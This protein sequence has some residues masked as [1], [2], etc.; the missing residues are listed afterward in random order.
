M[1][2]K[3]NKLSK[4]DLR[5]A[6]ASESS[7]FTPWLSKEE[8]INELG[9]TIGLDLTF[10]N[11][12]HN[13]GPYRADIICKDQVSDDIVLIENQLERTNHK[14]LGQ[15]LTY[16]SGTKAKTIV[17]IAS[18][19]TDEHR[20][21]LDWLNNHTSESF[22]FFGIE[23]ELL[24]I[25]ESDI[26]PNFKLVSKPN[27]W[28][29]DG[30]SYKPY[31]SQSSNSDRQIACKDYWQHTASMIKENKS[32]LKAQKPRAQHWYN[33]AVG[34]QGFKIAGTVKTKANTIG[35]EIYI[36]DNKQAFKNLESQKREIEAELGLELSWEY[37]EGKKASRIAIYRED[38]NL[39]DESRW[40]EYAEWHVSTFERLHKVFS[41]RIKNLSFNILKEAA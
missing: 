1:N 26:A 17:W 9:N 39:Y 34:K 32:F 37:L 25:G 27:D 23:I 28:S 10:E 15:I 40:N 19:F 11:S 29:K 4:V 7:D 12:E 6:W 22:N 30:S 31:N 33:V 18:E 16:A 24:K 36:S 5:E 41:P 20:A 8:N 3:F 13:V 2:I 14:H 21:T 35:A 38:A